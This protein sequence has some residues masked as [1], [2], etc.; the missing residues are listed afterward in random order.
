MTI[1]ERNRLV[2]LYLPDIRRLTNRFLR[3]G[4]R[5]TIEADDLYAVGCYSL[6]RDVGRG[7]DRLPHILNHAKS[8]MLE[9]VKTEKRQWNRRKSWDE[10]FTANGSEKF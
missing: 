3:A 6:V 8:Y 1:P 7:V 4:Q 10:M 2:E 9:F 5:P